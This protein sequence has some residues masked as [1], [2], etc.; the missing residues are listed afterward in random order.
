MPFFAV[1]T[2]YSSKTTEKVHFSVC[3]PVRISDNY[4]EEISPKITL[5]VVLNCPA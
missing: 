4:H 1:F 3:C 5:F 2:V